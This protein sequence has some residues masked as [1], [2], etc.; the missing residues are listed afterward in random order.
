MCQVTE[1]RVETL[2]YVL[3]VKVVCRLPT[4][5]LAREK[6][7][8]FLLPFIWRIGIMKRQKMSRSKSRKLFT[9]TA[10]WVH[11]RNIHNTPMRGGF[12]I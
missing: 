7:E 9:R 12:R 1:T 2:G 8:S 11:P 6:K 3:L 4:F 5:T 10:Q